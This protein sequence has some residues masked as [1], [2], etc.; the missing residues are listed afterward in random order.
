MVSTD[1]VASESAANPCEI[2]EQMSEQL[3]AI[4]GF[5]A[6]GERSALRAMSTPKVNGYVRS[7]STVSKSSSPYSCYSNVSRASLLSCVT[8]AGHGGTSILKFVGRDALHIPE[9]PDCIMK[10][11]TE[12]EVQVYE[13]LAAGDAMRPFTAEYH[14][15][16]DP[17]DIAVLLGSLEGKY[18]RLSNLLKGYGREPHVMDCKIGMRT[19]VE[20]EAKVSKPRNDL[21]KKLIALDPSAPTAEERETQECT[22]FRYMSFNDSFTTLGTLGFR[23]DGITHSKGRTPQNELKR[24]GALSEIVH[25]IVD[26]FMSAEDISS[27]GAASKST[28]SVCAAS[29]STTSRSTMWASKSSG[30]LRL[31]RRKAATSVLEALKR[32]REAML[33]SDLVK[34]HAF[35]GAS[36]LFITEA[37]GPAA[38]VYLIDFAK[39]LPLPTGIT[40][41]HRSK[42][43]AGN[44]EDGLFIGID[45]MIIC[46][47]TVLMRFSAMT[48]SKT[49][50][51]SVVEPT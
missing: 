34:S 22:K 37:D 11:Y 12:A 41:D 13:L 33:E 10:V 35:V 21:Y 7:M 44:Y 48:S 3:S 6:T 15:E 38:G 20:A 19:F 28:S 26:E 45:M 49:Y 2:W 27:V 9:V 43:E 51:F 18:I 30:V 5:D 4:D 1:L 50:D 31:D 25:R 36:L 24:L 23:I 47:E 42:W 8:A 39:T 14:G 40:I 32:I 16:V 46:W 29:K 17:D